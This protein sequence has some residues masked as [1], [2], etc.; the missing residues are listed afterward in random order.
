MTV[1]LTEDQLTLVLSNEFVAQL[2][3]GLRDDLLFK[4]E[5]GRLGNYAAVDF[6]PAG[7]LLILA[8]RKFGAVAKDRRA[9]AEQLANQIEQERG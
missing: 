7:R 8:L 2:D 4:I 6:G 9:T 5:T 3:P 1:T